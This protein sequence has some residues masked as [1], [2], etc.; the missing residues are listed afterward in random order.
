MIVIAAGGIMVINN[1]ITIGTLFAFYVYLDMLAHPM[2]DLPHLFMTGQQAFV[3][4]DRVEEIRSFPVDVNR[5]GGSHLG[6]IDNIE[7]SSIS[8]SYDGTRQNIKDA[9]FC[10]PSGTRVAIVGPVASGKSTLLKLLAGILEPTEGQIKINGRAISEWDW[11]SYRRLLGYV[12]QEGVL[13]SK[14][15]EENVLFGRGSG[16]QGQYS[17]ADRQRGAH[18]LSTAQMD[19]DL[20]EMAQGV[21]TLVGQKGALV[22]GG[23]K[24][25]IAIARSLAGLPQLLLLDD[26]TAALDAQNEDMFWSSLSEE[27]SSCTTFVVSHRLATIRRADRILVLEDGVLVD[28][29]VHEELALRCETY[30][31][32]LDTERRKAHLDV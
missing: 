2:M 32:F 29:G 20:A 22:S 16:E 30:R 3:S 13:F 23:Q 10:V 1:E 6:E 27:L 24:Q 28:E 9:T 25:R 12:P 15:V 18:C 14:S 31:E 21:D 19:S 11:D 26:C 5:V 7:F 17:E 4:V 8:F